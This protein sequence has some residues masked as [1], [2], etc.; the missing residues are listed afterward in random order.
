MDGRADHNPELQAEAD[1]RAW[2]ESLTP[3]QRWWARAEHYGPLFTGVAVAAVMRW[4]F[5]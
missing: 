1:E 4:A 2:L 5:A 3:R